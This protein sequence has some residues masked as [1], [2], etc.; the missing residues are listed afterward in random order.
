MDPDMLC[1]QFIQS[2]PFGRTKEYIPN[3]GDWPANNL[4]KIGIDLEKHWFRDKNGNGIYDDCTV[5][6]CFGHFGNDDLRSGIPKDLVPFRKF[7][8]KI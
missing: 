1:L 6:R 4:T 7:S 3:V 5:D 8:Q 2:V